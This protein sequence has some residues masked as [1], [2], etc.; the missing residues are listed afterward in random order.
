MKNKILVELYVVELDRL[1]DICIPVNEYV[2]R[3]IEGIVKSAFGIV[4]ASPSKSDYYLV[5][6]ED[7]SIYGKS[8]LVRD[9][10]IRNAKKIFLI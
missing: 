10:D 1:F 8:V 3:V 9:T 2:G 5:N 6:P 4:D 7:G